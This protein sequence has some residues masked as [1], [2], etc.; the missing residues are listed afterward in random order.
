MK[1]FAATLASILT[2]ASIAAGTA[3]ASHINLYK[4]PAGQPGAFHGG[5]V[6]VNGFR[7]PTGFRTPTGFRCPIGFRYPSG[8]RSPTGFRARLYK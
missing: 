1:R 2:V 8:F 6:H 7:R 4:A 3:A 5:S